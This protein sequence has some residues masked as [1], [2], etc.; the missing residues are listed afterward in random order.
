LVQLQ[1]DLLDI[2]ADLVAPGGHL[3]YAVCS[4]LAE[5]GRD[6]A[7]AF[8]GRRSAFVR[9]TPAINAGRAAGPGLLLSP[10]RDGTDGFFVARW[11]R[12]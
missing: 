8:A 5:E 4:L 2:A 7:E 1:A 12:A 10:R 6:Q 9:E 3:V 11:R